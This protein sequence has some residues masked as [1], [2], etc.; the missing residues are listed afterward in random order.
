M[1]KRWIIGGIALLVPLGAAYTGYW[2]WLAR[3][4][5]Q[6]L[7]LWVDQ[8]RAMGYRISYAAGEPGGYPLSIHIALSQSSST[9]RPGSRPGDST[10]RRRS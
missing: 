5:Q 3:T 1:R 6:N 2:F 4:F 9:R 10:R 7:A 8:Q